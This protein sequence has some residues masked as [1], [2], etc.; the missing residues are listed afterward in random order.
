MSDY[1]RRVE[2]PPVL[3]RVERGVRF[4]EGDPPNQFVRVLDFTREH[5]ES[6]RAFLEHCRRHAEEWNTRDPGHRMPELVTR[7]I[8]AWEVE[9]D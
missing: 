9:S 5:E 4:Y 8:P 1:P 6:R 2:D 7:T 3:P